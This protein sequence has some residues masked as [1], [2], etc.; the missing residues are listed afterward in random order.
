MGGV[1]WQKVLE[2]LTF[3]LMV[4]LPA[5]WVL[6]VFGLNRPYVERVGVAFLV[7]WFAVYLVSEGS[8]VGFSRCLTCHHEHEENAEEMP[9]AEQAFN[10]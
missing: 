1:R 2:N 5:A 7:F 6:G 8:E 4:S 3:M 10:E 9:E